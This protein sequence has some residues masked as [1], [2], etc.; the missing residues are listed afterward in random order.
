MK[1]IIRGSK[2]AVALALTVTLFG[3][4][5]YAAET[6]ST[7][8]AVEAQLEQATPV[9]TYEEALEKAKKHSVDLIDLQKTN[10]YLQESKEDLWDAVGSFS[11]PTY[12]Y[13]KWVN[14]A[15]YSYT[16]GIY[17]TDSGMTK[18]KYTTKIT[19][20]MLEAT[21]K[22]TFSS[23]VEDEA[24]LELLKKNCEIQKTLYEQGQ[25]KLSLGMLSQYKLDQL[26]ADYEKS[27]VN[28]FQLEKTLEQK[29]VNLSDLMGESTD[30]VYALEYNVEFEPY[31]L[32][33][34]IETYINAALNSDYSILLKEKAVEDAKF[35]QNFLSESTTNS[36]NKSNKLS[37]GTAQRALKSAKESKDV[38]IR[39]AYVQLKQ[40]EANYKQT[41][42]DLA[43][44]QADLKTT[45][46]N[47]QVG[48]VTELALE[49]AQLAVMKN[50]IALQKLA[51]AYDMQ[52]FA[53]KNT[54]LIGSTPSGSSSEKEEK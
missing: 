9:L 52:V 29:Y 23:I 30:K 48:N 18:N 19:N 5:A 25:T 11:I 35:K 20:L 41:E 33:G 26:K 17:N 3:T 49:Q 53:F 21:L 54:S 8:E 38:A 50:E 27:K 47:Y 34:T 4:T 31:E 42:S 37:Y 32:S 28:V 15:V 36:E 45:E 12:D 16:S 14:N 44:A 40:S 13:Q 2:G 24:D 22:S 7:T 10:D 6:P 51:D 39:N 1:K 43:Q 46:V